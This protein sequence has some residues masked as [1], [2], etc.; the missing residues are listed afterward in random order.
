MSSKR[1]TGPKPTASSTKKAKKDTGGS[2]SGGKR[3][4]VKCGSSFTI[5]APPPTRNALGQLVFEGAP[6]FCPNLTPK[7]VLQMGSFGGTYFR[8][9]KSGVTGESYRDVWKELPSDWLEGLNIKT[10]V[11]SSIY[12]TEVNKFKVKCGGSLEMWEESGWIDKQDPY[13]WF[14]WYCRYYQGRRSEDDERQIGRWSRCAGLKG[15]WRQN[16]V[17]KVFRASSKFDD[18]SVSPVVRQ[19][20]QHWGY[21]LN[22]HDYDLGVKRQKISQRERE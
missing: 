15:R 21:E 19:T 16:L 5:T 18:A 14:M 22:K 6:E 7:Q 1:K 20:L 12:D 13:G 9:I 3:V 10:Q 2:G 17:T 8:P 11:A 4:E